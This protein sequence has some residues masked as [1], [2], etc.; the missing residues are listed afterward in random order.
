MVEITTNTVVTEKGND[1]DDNEDNTKTN[2]NN[3]YNYN[4]C[5]DVILR[6]VCS[7]FFFN[8]SVFML[9]ALFLGAPLAQ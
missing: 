9:Y 5:D 3:D 6:T 7:C 1:P 4:N 8:Y 2:N